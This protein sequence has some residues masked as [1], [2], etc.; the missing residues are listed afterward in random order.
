VAQG[1]VVNA[2]VLMPS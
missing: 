2:L 1:F